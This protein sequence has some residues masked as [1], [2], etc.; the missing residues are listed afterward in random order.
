MHA[1]TGTSSGIGLATTQEVLAAGERVAAITRKA[2]SLSSLVA[3]HPSSSLQVVEFDVA[4]DPVAP[5][6]EKVK[7]HFGRLDVIV[8]NVGYGLNSVVE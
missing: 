6:F 5:L 3:E 8:N 2:A 7:A 4:N 1:V